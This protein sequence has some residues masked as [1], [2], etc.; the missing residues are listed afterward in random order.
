MVPS[1]F[2]PSNPTKSDVCFVEQRSSTVPLKKMHF[3]LCLTCYK[4][5]STSSFA[6]ASTSTLSLPI[7]KACFCKLALFH[8]TNHQ[9]VF[10]GR[11]IQLKKPLCTK[12]CIT[13][14]EPKI[15][16]HALKRNPTA[17]EATLPEAAL[18]VKNDF[19]MDDYLEPSPTVEEARR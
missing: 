15:R 16:Q 17:N 9:F 18:S 5:Q 14:L 4:T 6:S 7:L 2:P 11:R 19:Y 10:C 1:S 13:C 12:T 3:W 8:K